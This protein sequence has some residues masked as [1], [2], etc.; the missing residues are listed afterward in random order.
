MI[1]DF[2]LFLDHGL[3]FF[4][5]VRPFDHRIVLVDLLFQFFQTI[6]NQ[7]GTFLVRK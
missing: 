5:A 1:R 6:G 2:D 7:R 4:Q 3:G